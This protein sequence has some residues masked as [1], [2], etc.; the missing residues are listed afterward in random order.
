MG[1][2]NQKD[3]EMGIVITVWRPGWKAKVGDPGEPLERK[4]GTLDAG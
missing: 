3:Q 2:Q 4:V 1:K